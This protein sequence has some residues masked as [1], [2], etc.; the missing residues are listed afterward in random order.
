M[1]EPSPPEPSSIPLGQPN[2]G[3][4]PTAASSG[5]DYPPAAS[6]PGVADRPEV[7]IGATFVGGLVLATI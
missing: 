7:K 4:Q 2:H 1:T 5:A 6:G 3:A